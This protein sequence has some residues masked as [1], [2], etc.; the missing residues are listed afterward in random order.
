MT[1]V[2]EP[3]P[4]DRLYYDQYRYCVSFQLSHSGRSRSLDPE[5][6]R[7]S[8][9]FANAITWGGSQKVHITQEQNLLKCAEI[10]SNSNHD[11]KRIVYADWQYVYSNHEPL[12]EQLASLS[13]LKNVK[14]TQA[15]AILPR[16]VVL[17]K[18]S[19]YQFRSYF[20]GRWFNKEEVSAIKNFLSSRGKQFRTTPGVRSRLNGDFFYP[21]DWMFVDHHSQQDAFMLNLVVS[22]C[23]RKTLPI[24]TAK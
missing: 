5:K 23:I 4:R 10:L 21:N 2:Y 1:L 15:Q 14:T 13:F 18:N 20:S 11:Y 19:R 16:D 7:A 6:I 12:L 8:V 9:M 3:Q 17:L 24:Q 22:Q